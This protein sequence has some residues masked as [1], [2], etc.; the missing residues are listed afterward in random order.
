MIVDFWDALWV[1]MVTFSTVGYGDRTP[2][3]Y[4]GRTICIVYCIIINGER[5]Q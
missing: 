1:L 2:I 4:V 5:N 3:T